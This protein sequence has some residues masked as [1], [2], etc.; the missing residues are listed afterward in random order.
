VETEKSRGGDYKRRN[1]E[2]KTDPTNI[3]GENAQL[4]FEEGRKASTEKYSNWRLA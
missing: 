3:G 4:I 1:H 2:T